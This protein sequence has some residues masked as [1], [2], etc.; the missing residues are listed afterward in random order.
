MTKTKESKEAKKQ[1][2]KDAKKSKQLTKASHR[3]AK[4]QKL[5][6]EE[7]EDLESLLKQFDIRSSSSSVETHGKLNPCEQ[8]TPR[9]SASFTL[10]PK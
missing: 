8:P 6:G 10:L 4:Q 1:A 2:S 9:V 5:E 3:K 7:E